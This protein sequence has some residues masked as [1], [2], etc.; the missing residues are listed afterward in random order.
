VA[1]VAVCS[2]MNTKHINTVWAERT[3]VEYSCCLPCYRVAP[4]PNLLTAAVYLAGMSVDLAA[5]SSG[6]TTKWLTTDIYR[7]NV[8][9]W[10]YVAGRWKKKIKCYHEIFVEHEK[11][12]SDESKGPEH[13]ISS[14]NLLGFEGSF[15]KLDVD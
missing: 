6:L 8:I 7:H 3:V 10:D 5:K 13:F 9:L 2:Q 15:R 4:A 11:H 12:R 14:S 1:Q